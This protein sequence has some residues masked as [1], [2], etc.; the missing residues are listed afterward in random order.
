[1]NNLARRHR[2]G[3]EEVQGGRRGVDHGEATTGESDNVFAQLGFKPE[4]AL[5]LRLRSEMTNALMA[6]IEKKGLTQA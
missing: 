6:E 5:N 4:E 2:T 1:M 3:R